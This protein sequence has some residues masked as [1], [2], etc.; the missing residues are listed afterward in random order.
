MI[1]DWTH[2][3]SM[4]YGAGVDPMVERSVK[5]L[6]PFSFSSKVSGNKV[7]NA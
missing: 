6:Y 1:K 4:A 3:L 2:Y 7:I 5:K